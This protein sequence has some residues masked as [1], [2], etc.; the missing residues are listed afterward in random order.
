MNQKDIFS[1]GEIAI[2]FL[3]LWCKVQFFLSSQSWEK[4]R[5]VNEQVFAASN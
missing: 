1:E 2:Y 3:S 4:L 5:A